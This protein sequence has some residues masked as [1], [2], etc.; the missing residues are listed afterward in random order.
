MSRRE[1]RSLPTIADM[2]QESS[3]NVEITT[4][5]TEYGGILE[6]ADATLREP[7]GQIRAGKLAGKTLTAAILIVAAPVFLEQMLAAVVGL[8]DKMLT[9]GLPTGATPALDGVSVGA[10]VGWFMGIAVSSVGIGAQAIIARALGRGDREEAARGLGQAA[11]F[12]LAWGVLLGFVLYFGAPYLARVAGLSHDAQTACI[13][14]VRTIAFGAPFSAFTFIGIMALHGAGETTRPFYVM[15]VVNIVNIIA[16]WYLS[17][18]IVSLGGD[19]FVSPGSMGVIGIAAGTAIAR[20]VG[21]LLILG[22]MIRGVKDLR[23]HTWA[24][25][26]LNF[27]MLWRIIRIGIPSFLEGGGM[28]LGNIFIIGI[29]GMIAKQQAEAQHL[30]TGTVEGLMGAHIIAVQWESFSFLPGFAIGTAAA[31]LAGQYL[32]AGN[33]RQA[34]RALLACTAIAMV[35]MGLTG[36]AMIGYGEPLT[37]LISKDPLHLQLVPKLLLI[38]GVVQVNF[39]IAMVLRTGMRGAGDT[40]WAMIITW[41]S[42]YGIRLPAAYIIGYVLGHGLT[43]VWLAL[44]GEL[45]IRSLLFLARFLQGGWKRIAV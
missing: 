32:G 39:A 17:G 12:S 25:F 28:W 38:C 41:F 11:I 1:G 4:P 45:V 7:D 9:G 21:S 13:Q 42:T 26:P 6:G 30:A 18:S 34:T 35:F 22:L 19:A 29:V 43:G 23:L 20:V 5:D 10:Y 40:K 8:A 27:R 37:R 3:E 31:T 14:Y 2:R 15:I 44:C 24:T 33:A 16:S 36:G